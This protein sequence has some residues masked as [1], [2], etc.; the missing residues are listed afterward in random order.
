MDIM[1]HVIALNL[2]KNLTVSKTLKNLYAPCNN[3]TKKK[4]YII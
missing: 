4:I 2:D 1:R 3:F